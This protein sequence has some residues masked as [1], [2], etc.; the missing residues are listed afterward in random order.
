ME[1]AKSEN[2]ILF[3][4]AVVAVLIGYSEVKHFLASYLMTNHLLYDNAFIPFGT[5]L[6]KNENVKSSPSCST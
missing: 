5:T 3:G 2:H 1:T 4:D 6:F